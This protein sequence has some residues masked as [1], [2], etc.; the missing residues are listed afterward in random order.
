MLSVEETGTATA[1]DLRPRFNGSIACLVRNKEIAPGYQ[2]WLLVWFGGSGL[3]RVSLHERNNPLNLDDA[4]DHSNP[5]VEYRWKLA[6]RAQLC[7]KVRAPTNNVRMAHNDPSIT[8]VSP[9]I[10][11]AIP[12]ATVSAG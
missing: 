3:L 6:S 11:A 7:S 2:D 12:G 10:A 5:R 8:T 4:R 1:V 9:S